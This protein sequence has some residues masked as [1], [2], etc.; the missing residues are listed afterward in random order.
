MTPEERTAKSLG[1]RI[2]AHSRWANCEDRT[3]AMRPAHQSFMNRFERDVD[4]E[5]KLPLPERA[6][7]AEHAKKAYFARLALASAKARAR[8]K[9]RS[10]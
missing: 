4:P 6:V 10:A 1:G 7:R 8:R 5:G 2:G 3:A 9:H